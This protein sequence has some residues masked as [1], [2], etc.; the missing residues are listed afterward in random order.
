MGELYKQ[1]KREFR[2]LRP[3][4]EEASGVSLR[5]VRLMPLKKYLKI[6][7]RQPDFSEATVS[8]LSK[9]PMLFSPREGV[10]VV[11]E[12]MLL[13]EQAKRRAFHPGF[14]IL[15]ELCHGLQWVI[16]AF[17]P[18][19]GLLEED[20]ARYASVRTEFCQAEQHSQERKGL[21]SVLEGMLVDKRESVETLA[22]LQ[23]GFAVYFPLECMD[24]KSVDSSLARVARDTRDALRIHAA[25][26]TDLLD[27]LL[28]GWE[29]CYSK[30]YDFFRRVVDLAGGKGSIIEDVIRCCPLSMEEIDNP[31]LYWEQRLRPWREQQHP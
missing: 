8:F 20:A 18:L 13:V 28:P 1:V 4:V 10:V 24:L 7:K 5:E 31:L 2:R 11:N 17:Y 12:S 15:H 19:E 23:E 16:D 3:A 26:D 22:V 29:G 21:K 6:A 27:M 30:G 25:L 14:Y 9:I